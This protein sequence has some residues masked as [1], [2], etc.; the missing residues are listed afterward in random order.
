MVLSGKTNKRKENRVCEKR[1]RTRK[2][3]AR[4]NLRNSIEASL[5]VFKIKPGKGGFPIL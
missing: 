1:R 3:A 5:S 4:A 2:V